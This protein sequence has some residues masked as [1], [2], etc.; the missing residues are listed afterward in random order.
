MTNKEASRIERL[1]ELGFNNF[2]KKFN[3]KFSE[4]F[5][6]VNG[7]TSGDSPFNMK[8][9][10]CGD[11]TT[12]NGQI[13]RRGKVM[14]CDNCI[15]INKTKKQLAR[16]VQN[17]LKREELK[18][19][20]KIDQLVKNELA[21]IAKRERDIKLIKYCNEC[22]ELFAATYVKAICCSDICK[23]KYNNRYNE[24]NRRHKLRDNGKI[25]YSISIRSII[26]KNGDVCHIC[27]DRCDCDDYYINNDGH[28]IAGEQYP[29]I[30]HVIPVSHGGT[31]TWDNV[32]L[33]HRGCNS[34]KSDGLCYG[35]VNEQMRLS[36]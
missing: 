1:R 10:T 32:K 16:D 4:G 35:G 30:D 6:Y 9:K 12:R 31:H 29:S 17:I 21:V 8:C 15:E 23:R 33:A 18:Q 11:I 26:T 24:T 7:Y 14:T 25:D 22:G 2:I 13:V 3:D 5:E 27:L 20:Q 28:F 19:Q 36:I 34:L